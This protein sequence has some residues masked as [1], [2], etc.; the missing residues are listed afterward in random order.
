MNECSTA[1]SRDEAARYETQ[2]ERIRWIAFD[3]V[4]TLLF[5]D[6]PVGVAYHRVGLQHGSRY[7]LEEVD[8]RFRERFRAAETKDEHQTDESQELERWRKVVIEVFDD[9]D[10]P[11]SCFETLFAHFGT[12]QAWRCHREAKD[13]LSRLKRAGYQLALASNFDARLETIADG[14]ADLEPIDLRIISSLVGHKKPSPMFYG[15]LVAGAGCRPDEILMV[16]DDFE[17]DVAAPRRA[18]LQAVH[19]AP[20]A[21]PGRTATISSLTALLPLLQ[22]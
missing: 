20:R 12:P 16:G 13:V 3:G 14:L 1:S 11:Q 5:P 18:G 8:Q 4:G 6:P 7:T 19:F 10:N 15:A 21:E 22:L 9:V 2:V 17:N